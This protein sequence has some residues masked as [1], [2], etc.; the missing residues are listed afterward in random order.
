MHLYKHI[1]ERKVYTYIG[2]L[3]DCPGL[4]KIVLEILKQLSWSPALPASPVKVV[5]KSHVCS[6]GVTSL[7]AISLL[8]SVQPAGQAWLIHL[9]TPFYLDSCVCVLAL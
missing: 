2:I 8:R 6:L 5:N 9:V 7:Y 4:R 1:M 3:V